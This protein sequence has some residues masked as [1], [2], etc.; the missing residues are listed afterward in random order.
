[1]ILVQAGAYT[2]NVENVLVFVDEGKEI[3][4]EFNTPSTSSGGAHSIRI[5]GEAC[6]LVRTWLKNNA[7]GI[8][9]E[10]PGFLR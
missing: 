2:I 4:V 9:Q 5:G 1:M 10:S 7:E 3:V 6:E 8:R